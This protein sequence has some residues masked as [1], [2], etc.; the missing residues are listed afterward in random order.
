MKILL[1]GA[2]GFVGR[3]LVPQLLARGHRLTV[4]V[5]DPSSVSGFPWGADVE[6]LAFDLASTDFDALPDWGSQ[7]ALIHLAWPNLPNY[8]ASFHFE[9][10]LPQSYQFIKRCVERGIR[11]VLA[12]GT[13]FEY[14][15]RDGCLVE[16]MGA[17]P[18]NPYAFAKDTLRGFVELLQ[19]ETPL[20][21]QWA[22]LFYM[23]G[24]GQNPKSLLAQLDR[25]IDEGQPSFDMSLGEQLRDYL[26][27]EE[28][29]RRLALLLDHPTL[30][31]V[32]NIC[33]GEPI[34]VRRLVEQHIAKRKATIALN[35]GFYPYSPFEPLAFWGDANRMRQI[36]AIRDSD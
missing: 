26:P 10:N 5:R 28:V 31:G 20:T 36:D 14:G 2:T 21:F 33:S 9:A 25:A 11:H 17:R 32:T 19:K 29:A 4:L 15:M 16:S 30:Q 22:R 13:C 18:A 12:T 34:S 3:H 24:E 6:A 8:G 1:T 23:Y 35:L 27:I 7:D